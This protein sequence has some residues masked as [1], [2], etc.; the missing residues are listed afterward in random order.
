MR[1]SGISTGMA[2]LGAAL[3]LLP[4]HTIAQTSTSPPAAG[5]IGTITGRVLTETGA[6]IP[7]A[8]IVILGTAWG[9]MSDE[10]GTYTIRKIPT[11][12][13]ALKVMML[14]YQDITATDIRVDRGQTTAIDFKLKQTVA[15]DIPQIEIV[16]LRER[17][18]KGADD[19]VAVNVS[20]IAEQPIDDIEDAIALK[21]GVIAH[22]GELHFEG[23]RSNEILVQIDGIPVRDPTGASGIS[24]AALAL[25]SAEVIMGGL[26]AQYGN[27]QSGVIN[28]KTKEGGPSFEGE[29]YYLTDRY[30]QPENTYDNTDRI[31]LGF[32]GPSPVKDLT[33]Y[34]SAEGTYTDGYP[35]TQ[36]RRNRQ[37]VLNFL[38]FTDRMNNNLRL[39]GKVAY[40]LGPS[41]K[42]TFEQ[43]KNSLRSDNYVHAWSRAGWIQTLRDTTQTGDVVVRHGRWSETPIDSTYVYYNAAEHTPDNRSTVDQT[44]LVWTHTID[45]ATFYSVKLSRSHF[46]DDQRVGGKQPW[47]YEGSNLRDF[48]YDYANNVSSDFFVVWGDYPTWSHRDTKVTT[49][50]VDF[51]RKHQRHTLQTGVEANYNEMSYLA[52]DNPFQSTTGGQIGSDRTKYHVF[53]PEIGWYVQDRWEHEGMILNLGIRHDIFSVGEQI[54]I[55]EVRHPV[56]T[57]YSPRVGVAYPVSDR[58]VFSFHYG[59]YYQIPSRESIFDNRNAIDGRTRA[60][61]NLTNQTTV[62]YQAGIQ[63][64]F[65]DL[66]SG[67]FSLY[68]KDI[69][70]L[71]GMEYVQVIGA[72]AALPMYT[73]RDYASSRGFNLTLMRSFANNFRAEVNYSYGV[74]TGVASDPLAQQTQNFLYL[75]VSEQPLD[76]DVRHS[77]STQLFVMKNDAWGAGFVWRFSTGSPYTPRLRTT[78]QIE[79]EEENSRRLPS[80]TSLDVQ[81]NKYYSVWGQ[82]FNVFVR[83]ENLLDAKNVWLLEPANGVAG[84][85]LRGHDYLVYYT[86]TGRAGGAYLGE[87]RTGDGIE[88]FVPLNDP[89]VFGAPRSISVGLSFAF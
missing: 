47:E 13:Y 9:A 61:P 72:V 66:V 29:M 50:K 14:G 76:W 79:P 77:L 60:N 71:L 63:H 81:A 25:E 33:Y 23:G 38:S 30:G 27:A 43:L 70:G 11:G 5:G 69:F 28:Y 26:D 62:S 16:A 39:Q 22:A 36:E 48:Y 80:Q 74:A 52:V 37:K 75:P 51:T 4:S 32:G 45:A 18:N 56:K 2:L 58:D 21:R 46:V 86:E 73:N 84:T 15:A 89:R 7:F 42:I 88:D 34:L 85:A 41:Y 17:L 54:P 20:D 10:T 44:K 59:R 67:Q 53:N 68:Y 57:Q 40:R 8:N 83:S 1:S 35:R 12:N 3:A 65:S 19:R 55:N 64:L 31:F 87:D 78:R 82:R 49:G 24:L 6:P